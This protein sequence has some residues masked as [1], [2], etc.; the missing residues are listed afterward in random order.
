MASLPRQVECSQAGGVRSSRV[1]MGESSPQLWDHP[2]GMRVFITG[3]S[4]YLGRSVTAALRNDGHEIIALSRSPRS[5]EVLS[6]LRA[7]PLRGDIREIA[8]FLGRAARCDAFIHLAQ[9]RSSERYETDRRLVDALAQLERRSELHLIYTSTLFV[10]G[11]VTAGPV[12]ERSEARPPD[13]IAPRLAVERQVLSARRPGLITSVVRPGMVYGGG[14]GGSVSEFFRSA[15]EEG[16]AAYVGAGENRWTLI[17][18]DDAG[19]LYA[20]ALAHRCE[21][22]IHAV[23]GVP[24]AVREIARLASEAAGNGATRSIEL[25]EARQALGT[26][27]DALA[28]DQPAVTVRSH[29]L[30]WSPAWPPFSKSAPAAFEEWRRS[31]S[32][33]MER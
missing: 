11:D 14:E 29:E 24:M 22:I 21:G 5:D 31:E 16:A 17:H 4:G 23:D 12:D 20:A 25:A 1:G 30:G 32:A 6:G 15:V 26:F 28:L 7:A 13:F 8:S 10:F 2:Q 9:D 27:A 33:P 19:S 3:G 18:R